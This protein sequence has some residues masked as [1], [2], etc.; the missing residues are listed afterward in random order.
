M[1]SLENSELIW[2][3]TFASF[4]DTGHRFGIEGLNLPFAVAGIELDAPRW[5]GL[6]ARISTEEISLP[7]SPSMGLPS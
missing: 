4:H 3:I 5:H 6:H 1:Y 7:W 2:K